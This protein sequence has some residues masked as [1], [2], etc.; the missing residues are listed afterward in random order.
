MRSLIYTALFFSVS[1][2]AWAVVPPR[3]LKAGMEPS[4]PPILADGFE[5]VGVPGAPVADAGPDRNV[6]VTDPQVLD[7]SGSRDPGGQPL[8]YRWVLKSRPEGS[9]AELRDA[10]TVTPALVP[11][12]AGVYWLELTV[13]NGVMDSAPDLLRVRAFTN[14]G[15]DSDG[16]GLGDALELS[17]GLDPFAEDSFGDGIRDADR[18]LDN[19]GLTIRQELLIG[20][21]PIRADTDGNG[22]ND[23]AEDIDQD[24]LTNVEEFAAGTNALNPDT[25]GD[26]W[27]DGLEVIYGSNP[28]LASVIPLIKTYT[29]GADLHIAAVGQP[30]N[31]E[32]VLLDR[33]RQSGTLAEIHLDAVTTLPVTSSVELDRASQIHLATPPVTITRNPP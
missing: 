30:G 29:A 21:D 6:A 7:G 14:F 33:A 22:I 26:G 18:D 3:L 10:N 1:V 12:V 5:G 27:V 17:L 13:N 4:E 9:Q 19:D 20:T 31:L 8:R 2:T 11:D 32:E 28:L 15:I 24:G 16:D 23:G 25:D